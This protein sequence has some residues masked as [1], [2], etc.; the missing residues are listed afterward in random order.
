[1]PFCKQTT[2]TNPSSRYKSKIKSKGNRRPK[3]SAKSYTLWF[4]SQRD[5]SEA[6]L[7]KKLIYKE[8]STEEID[9]ALAYVKENNYQNDVRYSRIH[10]E[11][12]AP[13]TGNQ[14]IR[15][16]LVQKGVEPELISAQLTQLEPE[17]VRILNVVSKFEN[18]E[19]TPEFRQ[20]I[21]R[22]LAYRGF[23]SPAIKTALAH[24]A[25]KI[26]ETQDNV[27]EI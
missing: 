3:Q 14:R 6:S 23:S 26:K 15:Q 4:L 20:K 10:A 2:P 19:L 21:Y 25:E 16:L 8:Y 7:R 27:I 12:K 5:Y 17:D 9:E 24:L 18:K 1:M 11:A 22:F 13:R